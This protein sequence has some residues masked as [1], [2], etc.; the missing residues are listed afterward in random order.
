MDLE[1]YVDQRFEEHRKLHEL[2]RQTAQR[3]IEASAAVYEHR[4]EGLNELRGEV[5]KD[6][7][8]FLQ[9]GTFEAKYERIIDDLG[10][11]ERELFAIR[12]DLSALRGKAAA[13]AA[14]LT[15]FLVILSIVVRIVM[16]T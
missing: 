1:R 15:I 14:A 6:R 9:I 5:T 8:Q 13:F 7:A 12:E 3:A 2:E 16:G 10:R 11:L 4:L